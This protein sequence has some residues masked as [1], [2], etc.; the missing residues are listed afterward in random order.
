MNPRHREG[1]LR[2]GDALELF[3]H[4]KLADTFFAPFVFPSPQKADNKELI[5]SVV[6]FS[7]CLLLVEAKAKEKEPFYESQDRELQ[8]AKGK[9]DKALRQLKGAHRHLRDQLVTGLS[10]RLRGTVAL[11][12][13]SGL[14]RYG[15]ILLGHQ[16]LP[17]EPHSLLPD[18]AQTE[19]PVHVFSARDFAQLLEVLTTPMDFVV[20]LDTR[21]SVSG[22]LN[23]RVHDERG[24]FEFYRENFE[25]LIFERSRRSKY[26]PRFLKPQGDLLREGKGD[27]YKYSLVIDDILDHCC[28]TLR[29]RDSSAAEIGLSADPEAIVAVME[30]IGLYTRLHRVHL[31]KRFHSLLVAVTKAGLPGQFCTFSRSTKRVTVFAAAQEARPQRGENLVICTDIALAHWQSHGAEM[32]LGISTEP[33][34]G[35][36]RSYDFTLRHPSWP[37]EVRQKLAGLYPVMFKGRQIDLVYV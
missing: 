2:P 18:L 11:P 14:C 7:D 22:G 21:A 5:D 4:T 6:Y 19:F 28:A 32:G 36:G 35:V 27:T 10:S 15:L 13:V 30:Q 26:A 20:Y 8:W 3:A 17:Y 24:F 33:L 16:A 25:R 12:P 23:T 31:G 29:G 1:P 37:E 34:Q 9:L